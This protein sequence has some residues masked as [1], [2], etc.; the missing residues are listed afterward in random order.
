MLPSLS[1]LSKYWSDPSPV[2][3]QCARTVLGL[4][5]LHWIGP[6]PWALALA[7]GGSIAVNG[8]DLELRPGPLGMSAINAVNLEDYVRGVVAG[9]VPSSWPPEVRAAW[10]VPLSAATWTSPALVGSRLY[11]RSK[12]KLLCFDLAK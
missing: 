8:G 12:S 7:V 3:Q 11:V 1:T 10:S 5:A 2:L 9:E 6:Q 4:A